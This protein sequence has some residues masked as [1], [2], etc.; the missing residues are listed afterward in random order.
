[1]LD[2]HLGGSFQPKQILATTPSDSSHSGRRQPQKSNIFAVYRDGAED[3]SRNLAYIW[4]L[5]EL[6]GGEEKIKLLL[7][8]VQN[9]WRAFGTPHVSDYNLHSLLSLA[10]QAMDLFIYLLNF[11]PAPLDNVGIC[12]RKTNRKTP[13]WERFTNP[14]LEAKKILKNVR[15]RDRI[16]ILSVEL[17]QLSVSLEQA[18]KEMRAKIPLPEE[19]TMIVKQPFVCSSLRFGFPLAKVI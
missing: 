10:I 16:G 19:I 14:G 1:M 17:M 3:Q 5:E 2:R 6:L 15:T 9:I 7:E 13:V 18:V 11:Y 12:S 4:V 8:V